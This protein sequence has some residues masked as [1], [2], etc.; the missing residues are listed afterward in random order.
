L[1][2]ELV[3]ES[4]LC[5][6]LGIEH[7][8]ILGGMG[9][10]SDAELAAAVSEAGGLGTIASMRYTVDEL[11]AELSKAKSIT[12]K[13]FSV[14]VSLLRPDAE[15]LINVVLES[16]VKTVITAAGS[17][18]KFT[19]KLKESGANV[20]HVVANVTM[21]VKTAEAGVDV[22]IAEGTESGGVASREEITTLTLIPQV[23]DAV[24]LPVVA[25]G[26]IGD[27]RGYLAAR[28][29]GAEGVQMG[30][31]F[32]ASE[33]CRTIGDVYKHVLIEANDA[34]TGIAARGGI[35]MRMIKNAFF[36]EVEKAAAEGKSS[37]EIFKLMEGRMGATAREADSGAFVCGQVAG[38]IKEVRPVKKIIDEIVSGAESIL[39]KLTE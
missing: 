3:K 20:M 26:G 6:M 34:A 24:D 32:L 21:A 18:R 7:P 2:E 39:K 4:R 25:A 33:E 15:D 31:I 29:L 35:G 1:K 5:S 30:T 36:E 12:D 17:P 28:V 38:M 14:N 37:G 22:I 16:G 8:I 13:P 19:A 9:A 23:V 27:A 10:I 11:K